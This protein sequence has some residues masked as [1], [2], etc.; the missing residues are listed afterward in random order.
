M[1]DGA[2][3]TGTPGIKGIGGAEKEPAGRRQEE[4][5]PARLAQGL[6]GSPGIIPGR[7]S[8][9]GMNARRLDHPAASR[10]VHREGLARSRD[11]AGRLPL[12]WLGIL[13][14]TAP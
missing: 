6:D 1:E 2:K 12:A 10:R 11:R 5:H 3:S 8:R 9:V 4:V 13:R 14:R 7:E